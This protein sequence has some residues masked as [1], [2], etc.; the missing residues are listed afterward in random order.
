[1]T[2]RALLPGVTGAVA[3]VVFGLGARA[4]AAQDVLRAIEQTGIVRLAVRPDVE[5]FSHLDERS[6]RYEGY[7]VDLCRA[8]VRHLGAALERD[9][10]VEPVE[11]TALNRFAALR[12]GQADLLCEATTVTVERPISENVDFSMMTFVTG[13]TFLYREGTLEK[14]QAGTGKIGAVTGTTASDAMRAQNASASGGG[15]GEP[16]VYFRDYDQAAEALAAG[17][18]DLLL[19][20]R[21]VLE[22]LLKAQDGLG[23]D[24]ALSERFLSYEPYALAL[25]AGA[26]ELRYHVDRTLADLYRSG[27]IGKLVLR[28]FSIA[29]VPRDL[30]TMFRLNALP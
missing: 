30:A 21:L 13:G 24:V 29:E 1:M 2:P 10:R 18:I 15:P 6:G 20:D 27:E 4:A 22:R 5:P 26:R 19:G 3:L 28:H 12:E 7:S 16:Q 23:E 11:V 8:V 9:L 14:G 25:P 17:R